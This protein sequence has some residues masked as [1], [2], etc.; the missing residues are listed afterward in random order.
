MDSGPLIRLSQ[1]DLISKIGVLFEEIKIPSSVYQEVVIRG[2]EKGYSDAQ[3]AKQAVDEK[4]ILVVE[5]VKENVEHVM[6]AVSLYGVQLGAGEIDA[7]SLGFDNVLIIDDE[8]A[9]EIANR[10]NIKTRGTLSLLLTMVK[11]EIITKRK[12]LNALEHMID[13]GFWVSPRIIHLFNKKLDTLN[14]G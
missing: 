14:K 1:T 3:I 4:R 10:L 9:R 8:N 2:T 7:I 5:P 12:A 13:N 11:K 6:K